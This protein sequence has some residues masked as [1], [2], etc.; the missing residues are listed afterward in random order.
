LNGGQQ[1]E[2]LY[3]EFPHG[4]VITIRTGLGS[5]PLHGLLI[6]GQF[7]TSTS[8]DRHQGS[9]VGGPQYRTGVRKM[10]RC[11]AMICRHL[12]RVAALRVPGC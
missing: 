4:A 1:A 11:A 6:C 8:N 10:L 3:F 12:A 7:D 5:K 2:P 9:A